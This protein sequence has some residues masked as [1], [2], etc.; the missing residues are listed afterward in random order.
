[1]KHPNKEI[2]AVIR[3]ART[4]GWSVKAAGGHAW[5]IL[6]CP[7]NSVDCRCGQFC[8]M[9]VWSSPKNPGNFARRLQ[10]KID[11]CIY[12]TVDKQEQRR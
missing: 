10:H 9:S 8:R 12:V 6:K 4:K 5:G 3:Y 2:D 11:A 1:M 7:Q